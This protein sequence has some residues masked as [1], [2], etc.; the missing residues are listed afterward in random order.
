MLGFLSTT[1]EKHIALGFVTN[2]MIEIQ[3]VDTERAED[4]DSGYVFLD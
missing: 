1:L 4:L 2:A 3:V